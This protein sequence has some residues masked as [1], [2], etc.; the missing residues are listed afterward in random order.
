MALGVC[1]NFQIQIIL[2]QPGLDRAQQIPTFIITIK[3][4]IE[5]FFLWA[6]PRLKEAIRLFKRRLYWDR[7]FTVN[8]EIF[9]PSWHPKGF[10][11]IG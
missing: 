8:F 10:R 6:R 9:A 2:F 11:F 7:A 3:L 1:I 4:L 5:F